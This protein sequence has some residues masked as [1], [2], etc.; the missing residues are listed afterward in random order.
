MDKNTLSSELKGKG[1]WIRIGDIETSKEYLKKKGFEAKIKLGVGG[2]QM[3]MKE[4]YYWNSTEL[5]IEKWIMKLL[6][7]VCYL[8]LLRPL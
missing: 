8:I 4:R 1:S 6:K 2:V 7:K 3:R 5:F